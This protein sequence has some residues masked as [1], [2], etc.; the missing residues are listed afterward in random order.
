VDSAVVVAA[1]Q[2]VM[3]VILRVV[4]GGRPGETEEEAVLRWSWCM[5]AAMASSVNG[6]LAGTQSLSPSLNRFL[7]EP[8]LESRPTPAYPNTSM[9][10]YAHSIRSQE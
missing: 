10:A 9:A 1:G 4:E 3:A 2:V 5:K 7:L 8:C 6:R